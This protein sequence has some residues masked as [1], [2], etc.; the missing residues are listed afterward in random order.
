[1]TACFEKIRL[2]MLTF[3]TVNQFVCTSFPFGFGGG[4]RDL[5]VLVPDHLHI[6]LLLI[7]NH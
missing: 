3:V 6:D 5:I 1:M 4:M 2:T 7:V